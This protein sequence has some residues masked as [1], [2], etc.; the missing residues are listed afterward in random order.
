MYATGLVV[1]YTTTGIF[2]FAQGAIGAFCAFLYWELHVNQGWNTLLAIFAVVGVVA[3]LLGV[4]IDVLVMRR[5]QGSA[6]V[7]QLMVT[8]G[9]MLFFLGVTSNIWRPTTARRVNPF[10]GNAGF[11]LGPIVV[12]WHRL[13]TVIVA[14]GI[15]LLLRVVLYRTRLGVAMRA[16]VDNRNLAALNGARPNVISASAWA[17]GCSMAAIAGILIAPSQDFTPENFNVIVIVAFAAAAFGQL[18]NLPL[19]LVGCA[20]IGIGRTFAQQFLN[21]GQDWP[22][23]SNAI[24][25]ILLFLVVLALPQARLEVGRAVRNLKRVQRHTR[26]WEALL[27]MAV[28]FVIVLIWSNSFSQVGLNRSNQAMY[29]SIIVLSLI[30]L[31]GWAGQVNF[32]PLAFAGFGAFLFQHFAG[33]SGNMWYLL[34]VTALCAP[35]GALVALPAS[36]LKG[37]YLALA[38]MAFAHGMALIFFPHP[39]VFPETASNEAF[40]PLKVFGYTFDERR[41]LLLLMTGFFCAILIGLVALRRSRFGRRWVAFNDSPAA[42][43][44]V[45]ID[46]R[47]TTVYVYALSAAIA[48][49][50][51]ALMGVARGIV[52]EQDYDLLLGLPFV[53]LAAVG[54]ITYPIAGLFAGIST[55]LFIVVKERWDLSIFAALEVLGPGLMAIGLVF[56]QNGAVHDMGRGFAPLLP[57]RRDAR[58]ELAREK[59]QKREP[60]VGDLGIAQAFTNDAVVSLDRKLGILAD[61]TPDGGYLQHRPEERARAAAVGASTAGIGIDGE[62]ADVGALAGH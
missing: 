55:V 22:Q 8:V 10:Y 42:C 24:A 59:A 11:D 4:L 30:P 6:L 57:W 58:E 18:K 54:G 21:F 2:N 45:G 28:L 32:A 49:F 31:T 36:R 60:E 16:V 23:A 13:I 47:R 5:L 34:L 43:A 27:G 52:I 53:L 15:A 56:N 9:L 46:V 40:Q 44:T 14:L 20:I 39:K 7:L 12:Q 1:V 29:T 61:V 26:T 38:S 50:G 62:E 41:S 37:L 25:P 48:G 19:T 35:L 33:D 3:P 51:G 17:I